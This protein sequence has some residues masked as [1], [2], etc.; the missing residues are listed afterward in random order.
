MSIAANMIS[1]N[2]SNPVLED[3]GS[4]NRKKVI[5]YIHVLDQVSLIKHF[6]DVYIF[7]IVDLYIQGQNLRLD[8]EMYSHFHKYSLSRQAY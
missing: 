3:I 1:R 6:I 7:Y 2:Q 8:N 5:N 4:H